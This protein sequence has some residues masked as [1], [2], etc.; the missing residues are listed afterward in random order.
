VSSH[1][2]LRDDVRLEVFYD[3]RTRFGS[4]LSGLC[5]RLVHHTCKPALVDD[6]ASLG[7][8]SRARVA[9]CFGDGALGSLYE[10]PGRLREEC[11][12]PDADAVL[13]RRLVAEIGGR[14]VQLSDVCWSELAPSIDGIVD[15]KRAARSPTAMRLRQSLADAGALTDARQ[16][17]RVAADG[18]TFVGHA[19]VAIEH[20]G[21]R[22]LFDP[23]LMPPSSDDPRDYRPLLASELAPDAVFITHS[24]PDHY[25][26]G[27]LLRLGADTP[28]YVPCVE[29]ESLLAIDMR[30][31]LEQLGFRAVRALAWGQHVQVGPHRVFGEPLLGEQP[32][33]GEVLHPELR[34][35]GNT[36]VVEHPGCRVALLADAGRDALG[37]S[38]AQ[39]TEW[40]RRFGDIDVVL[41]GYRAWRLWPI[42]YP[43]TSVARY[44]LFV[45][46][47]RW[48]SSMQIMNDA[49]DLLELAARCGARFVVPYANGGAP[50]YWRRGLGPAADASGA[51]LAAFDPDLSA[52]TDACAAR[53]SDTRAQLVILRPG[54]RLVVDGRG[55]SEPI[56]GAGGHWP[57][58]H[59][60]AVDEVCRG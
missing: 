4:A 1:L 32:T 2:R 54:E 31:R 47:S 37:S 28:I 3:D 8:S 59:A 49:D 15:P 16:H 38:V 45:P 21:V 46:P 17:A 5:D 20:A 40:R 55:A 23:F 18:I 24:H 12:H 41:G 43:T 35:V 19:T 29:R 51:S 22:L 11:R 56:A 42:Q 13:P 52:L 27:S 26:L 6:V 50:W 60:P 33:D 9:A 58:R 53:R 36:Y 7:S 44:L 34:N 39:A 25:D 10:R 48:G 14:R 57:Y 30:M